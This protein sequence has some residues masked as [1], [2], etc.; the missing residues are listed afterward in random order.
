M[1]LSSISG[2]LVLKSI[3]Y[4]GTSRIPL[5]NPISSSGPL[6]SGVSR[7]AQRIRRQFM[8]IDLYESKKNK[9]V[10]SIRKIYILVRDI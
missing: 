3:L 8:N 9:P 4:A 2:I 10:R 5:M 1:L 6:G 7:K